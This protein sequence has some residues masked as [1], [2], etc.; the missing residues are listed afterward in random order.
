MNR[1]EKY[2]NFREQCSD[3]KLIDIL[4]MHD[5]KVELLLNRVEYLIEIVENQSSSLY[6]L[7]KDDVEI[8]NDNPVYKEDF[9]EM[10]KETLKAYDKILGVNE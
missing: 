8:F 5:K 7:A 2:R 6:E 10:F 4:E 1:T 9:D 3:T